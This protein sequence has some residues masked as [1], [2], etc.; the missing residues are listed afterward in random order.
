MLSTSYL[1][2]SPSLLQG[3]L[4]RAGELLA[5][6][7][8]DGALHIVVSDENITPPILVWRTVLSIPIT[9]A[10]PRAQARSG[11]P[12]DMFVHPKLVMRIMLA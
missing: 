5:I 3:D 8:A 2:I 7:L 9:L 4:G 6:S 1:F 10:M 12:I 11:C